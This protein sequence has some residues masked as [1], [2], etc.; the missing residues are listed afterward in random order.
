MST[1]ALSP[2]FCVPAEHPAALTLRGDGTDPEARSLV[3]VRDF[4]VSPALL[5]AAYSSSEHMQRWYGPKGCALVGCEIDFR[6]GGE[7][8]FAMQVPGLDGPV[9]FGGVYVEIVE[10][11]R[12]VYTNADEMTPED[13]MLIT[14]TFEP[15]GAETRLTIHTVF[16]SVALKQSQEA[17]GW[18]QGIT[19]SL[20]NLEELLA[21]EGS[22]V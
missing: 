19:S 16:C 21:D 7:L 20:E 15:R 13:T 8:R 6:V 2:A 22:A 10:N 18:V 1:P 17:R 14:V 12:L 5:F 4:A 9:R 3:I 11:E